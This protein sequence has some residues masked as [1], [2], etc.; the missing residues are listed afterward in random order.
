VAD[1]FAAAFPQLHQLVD[2]RVE[3]VVAED[4][5]KVL[6]QV[7]EV[8]GFKQRERPLVDFDDAEALGT[9]LEGSSRRNSRKSAIPAAFQS[10]NS[11]LTAL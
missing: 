8:V 3:H 6:H 1:E 9:G 7:S 4:P 5:T 10:A 11:A 2:E